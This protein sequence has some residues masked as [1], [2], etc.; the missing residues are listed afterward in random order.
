MSIVHHAGNQHGNAND[1]S[2]REGAP[3]AR[4]KCADCPECNLLAHTTPVC[5]RQQ[6]NNPVPMPEAKRWDEVTTAATRAPQQ[7]SR[8]EV[9]W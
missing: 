3:Q 7:A 4:C 6:A 9:R 8:M 1:L 2:H 5:T